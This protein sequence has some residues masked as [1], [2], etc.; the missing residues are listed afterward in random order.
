[1]PTVSLRK[2]G[3]GFL[4]KYGDVKLALDTGIK[5]E[6][7]LLSHSHSDHIGGLKNARHIIATKGTFDTWQARRSNKFQS[8]TIIKHGDMFGQIGVN[9]TALNAG[10]VLGSTM[11]LLEFNDGLK[12]LYTGD[13]NNVDSLVHKAAKPVEADVLITEATYGTPQWVFPTRKTVYDNI[14]E[15]AK[16]V[17]D[18]GRIPIFHAYSLGKSQE[19]IALLQSGGVRVISGNTSIDKVCSVY[20]QYGIE[21]RHQTVRSHNLSETLDEGAVI[22]SS[23]SRHTIDNLR[24]TLGKPA[25]GQYEAKFEYFNLSGWTIGKFRERGF[26]LSAHSDFNGLLNFA[27]EV[28][29]RVAYCFTENGR[30]LSKHLSDNDIHAVPLE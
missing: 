27:K 2:S 16:R 8:Q 30:T 3:T 20:K 12:V 23:S 29:P 11:Y 9:I 7:T 19:A 21:L 28:K 13:F 17:T 1:M 26:P 4:L 5:G 24:R 18:E 6:T 14:M 25:F 10:H 22:V 15:T